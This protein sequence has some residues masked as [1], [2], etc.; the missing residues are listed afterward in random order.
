MHKTALLYAKNTP[1]VSNKAIMLLSGLRYKKAKKPDW[2][3]IE[4]R[5]SSVQ[6]KK[7]SISSAKI[8]KP[9]S[10][11]AREIDS[12]TTLFESAKLAYSKGKLVSAEQNLLHIL[13]IIQN[14]NGKNRKRDARP[15]SA[16]PSRNSGYP[17]AAEYSDFD[18]DGEDDEPAKSVD[19]Y[20]ED[21][22]ENVNA[23][24]LTVERVKSIS[25]S[26][27]VIKPAHVPHGNDA[28]LE[29]EPPKKVF[30][31]KPSRM[32]ESITDQDHQS[33]IIGYDTKFYGDLEQPKTGRLSDIRKSYYDLKKQPGDD[34]SAGEEERAVAPA[35]VKV[36][37]NTKY[38]SASP[39]VAIV[40]L[41]PSNKGRL[42]TAAP[43]A[44]KGNIKPPLTKPKKEAASPNARPSTPSGTEKNKPITKVPQVVKVEP[45][46]TAAP[47]VVKYDTELA[48]V[49]ASARPKSAKPSTTRPASAKSPTSKPPLP[50]TSKESEKKKGISSKVPKSAVSVKKTLKKAEILEPKATETAKDSVTDGHLSKNGSHVCFSEDNENKEPIIKHASRGE[51]SVDIQGILKNTGNSVLSAFAALDSETVEAKHA[52]DEG[53]SED[54]L[55][56]ERKASIKSRSN[57]LK[58][59]H[60][61]DTLTVTAAETTNNTVEDDVIEV[62]QP[63]ASKPPTAPHAGPKA[64]NIA[65]RSQ[66]LSRVQSASGLGPSS[67]SN[68]DLSSVRKSHSILT[69]SHKAESKKSL[70]LSKGNLKSSTKSLKSFQAEVKRS[71]AL[72]ITSHNLHHSAQS[73][74]GKGGKGLT[75]KDNTVHTDVYVQKVEDESRVGATDVA[76][77]NEK[78][79]LTAES[80][81]AAPMEEPIIAKKEK[82]AQVPAAEVVESVVASTTPTQVE[83]ESPT[84]ARKMSIV[85]AFRNSMNSLTRRGSSPKHSPKGSADSVSALTKSQEALRKGTRYS[86]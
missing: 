36:N 53:A 59:K 12:F 6:S 77:N 66:S 76:I 30:V 20:V 85:E 21:F 10:L 84:K 45:I 74:S 64:E 26:D 70:N 15:K 86:N 14:S 7:A 35:T 54:H 43:K 39:K 80:A 67:K 16:R 31:P 63:D 58:A 42:A 27:A 68:S 24:N 47:V 37:K 22:D 4:K 73:L 57:S 8:E 23:A 55:M 13:K 40:T 32:K 46:V 60:Y 69:D 28:H 1:D 38:N 82:M 25:F 33:Y 5:I 48:P 78:V 62:K 11:K 50:N 9:A 44:K 29:V 83:T 41:S 71:Q 34:D 17:S 61:A 3:S 75:E 65:H 51:I 56:A 18:S 81:T 52:G 49:N 19:I 79:P 2:D 72:L